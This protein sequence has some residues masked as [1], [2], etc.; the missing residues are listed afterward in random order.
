LKGANMQ[1]IIEIPVI[2]NFNEIMIGLEKLGFE[3]KEKNE[4]TIKVMLPNGWSYKHNNIYDRYENCRTISTC[5]GGKRLETRFLT[6]YE[7][8][9]EDNYDKNMGDMPDVK[10]QVIDRGDN[11]RIIHEFDPVKISLN[12]LSQEMEPEFTKAKVWLNQHYSK[13]EKPLSYWDD[14]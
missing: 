9:I 6:R 5:L 11:S 4:Q 7:Y 10:I 2:M 13:W 3:F 8:I 12:K 14:K 1:E